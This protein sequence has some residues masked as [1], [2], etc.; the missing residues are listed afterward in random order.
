M[1]KVQ[2]GSRGKSWGWEQTAPPDLTFSFLALT[3]LEPGPSTHPC[4]SR[5]W[6]G[7]FASFPKH[8]HLRNATHV[9]KKPPSPSILKPCQAFCLMF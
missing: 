9:A 3:H 2:T 1:T 6:S 5:P 8:V 4:F 7:Q